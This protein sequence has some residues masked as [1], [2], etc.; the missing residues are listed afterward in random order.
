MKTWVLFCCLGMTHRSETEL[1][2]HRRHSDSRTAVACDGRRQ[3]MDLDLGVQ[4]L[5]GMLLESTF[6]CVKPQVHIML[7]PTAIII[8][9]QR[10]FSAN[11]AATPYFGPLGRVSC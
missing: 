11:G 4:I 3:R 8:L 7:E 6:I 9:V 1:H 5:Y 10:P 2:S